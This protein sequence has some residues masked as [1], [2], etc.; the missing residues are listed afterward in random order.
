M[1]DP[2]KAE[3]NSEEDEDVEKEDDGDVSDRSKEDRELDEEAEDRLG[4]EADELFEN[5]KPKDAKKAASADETE[6]LK[7]LFTDAGAALGSALTALLDADSE[8]KAPALPKVEPASGNG[9]DRGQERLPEVPDTMDGASVLGDANKSDQW[10]DYRIGFRDTPGDAPRD[11]ALPGV[12]NIILGRGVDSDVVLTDE[13]VSRRHAML[14][15]R[16]GKVFVEDLGSKNGTFI[17]RDGVQIEVPKGGQVELRPGDA[18]RLGP[19][20]E[21]PFSKPG[22]AESFKPA[23]YKPDKIEDAA[24][25]TDRDKADPAAS[26]AARDASNEYLRNHEFSGRMPDGFQVVGGLNLIDEKGQHGDSRRPSVVIDTRPGKDPALTKFL[27]D[28]KRDLAHLKDKPE[29]L[30]REIAKRA[31]AAM[32]PDGWSERAVDD[33][34]MKMRAENAG[35]RLMLGDFIEAA[36][37]GA[38]CGVCNHQAILTKL[39]FDSMYPN[40]SERPQMKLVRG[41]CGDDPAGRAPEYTMNHAWNTLTIDG[42]EK[43]FDPRQQ[44]YGD[45]VEARPSHHPGSEIPQLRPVDAAPPKPAADRAQEVYSRMVGREVGYG[46]EIWKIAAIDAAAGKVT[47]SANGMRNQDVESITKLNAGRELRIGET[48]KINRSNGS[49]DDGWKLVGYKDPE[50]KK[51]LIFTKDGAYQRTVPMDALRKDNEQVFAKAEQEATEKPVTPPVKP[52]ELT[53]KAREYGLVEGREVMHDGRKWF[54]SGT[55]DGKMELT[56]PSE[57]MM[58]PD[59]YKR[60]NGDRVPRVGD[61]INYQRSTGEVQKWRVVSYDAETGAMRVRNENAVK[62]TVPLERLLHENPDIRTGHK[63]ADVSAILADP[64]SKLRIDC[65]WTDGNSGHN[66]Y[67]GSIEGPNG[68]RFR[69]MVH[70]PPYNV[71]PGGMWE[72]A[73]KD[74]AAQKLAERMGAPGLFPPTVMRDGMMVQ[75]FVGNEGENIQTYLHQMSRQ[76]KDLRAAHRN[77]EDRIF[78]MMDKV[79]PKL[80]T[81]L[82]RTVA[83]T[84]LLGD[85]DQHGLNFVVERTGPNPGDVRIARIDMDHAFSRDGKPQIDRQGNYGDVVNGLFRYFSEKEMPAE[86]RAQIKKVSDELNPANAADR[87]AARNKFATETGLNRAR[88]DALADRAKELS[89]TGKFPKS[90]DLHARGGDAMAAPKDGEEIGTAKAAGG[91]KIEEVIDNLKKAG[92]KQ[93]KLDALKAAYEQLSKDPVKNEEALKAI[94]ALGDNTSGMDRAKREAI[95]DIVAASSKD[96]TIANTVDFAGLRDGKVSS[97][98]AGELRDTISR[99]TNLNKLAGEGIDANTIEKMKGDI[100]KVAQLHPDKAVELGKVVDKLSEP[101]FA[102]AFGAERMRS[103]AE[104]LSIP[105]RNE[106]IEPPFAHFLD[107]KVSKESLQFAA[108]RYKEAAISFKAP[109]GTDSFG[110]RYEYNASIQAMK[111]AKEEINGR[112]LVFIPAG[113]GSQADASGVDGVFMD[114]HTGKVYPIDWTANLAGKFESGKDRWAGSP[115]RAVIGQHVPPD[116]LVVKGLAPGDPAKMRDYIGSFVDRPNAAFVDVADMAKDKVPFPAF[117]ARPKSASDV[118]ELT[119]LKKY[120]DFCDRAFGGRPAGVL[121]ELYK[122]SKDAIPHYHA[123]KELSDRLATNLT[124]ELL[125]SGR[126]EALPLFDQKKAGVYEDQPNGER[127]WVRTND[128]TGKPMKYM[129]IELDKTLNPRIDGKD[130]KISKIRLYEDGTVI[131]IREYKDKSGDRERELVIG[132][133]KD[134]SSQVKARLE[135]VTDQGRKAQLQSLMDRMADVSAAKPIDFSKPNDLVQAFG[136]AVTQGGPLKIAAQRVRDL[137]AVMDRVK[138][139]DE[140]TAEE[141]I[142]RTGGKTVT[143]A[144]YQRIADTIAIEKQ[145]KTDTPKAEQILD[146]SAELVNKEGVDAGVARDAAAQMVLQSKTKEQALDFARTMAEVRALK[147]GLTDAQVNSLAHF[148]MELKTLVPDEKSRIEFRSN[149]LEALKN[150]KPGEEMKSVYDHMFRVANEKALAGGPNSDGWYHAYFGLESMGEK[151]LAKML[152]LPESADAKAIKEQLGLVGE[153]LDAQERAAGI[154]KPTAADKLNVSAI[155]LNADRV[156]D[157]HE[158]LDSLSATLKAS[159]LDAAERLK[160]KVFDFLSTEGV[161]DPI[162]A[163]KDNVDFVVS[164]DKTRTEVEFSEASSAKK[165]VKVDGKFFLEGTTTEVPADKVKTKLIIPEGLI[166]GNSGEL[167]RSIYSALLDIT[168]K[169]AESSAA[170]DRAGIHTFV[171]TELAKHVPLAGDVGTVTS[172]SAALDISKLPPVDT[173]VADLQITEK[174][175][176]IGGLD[177]EVSFAEIWSDRIKNLEDK[178]KA[179]EQKTEKDEKRIQEL[180]AAIAAEREFHAALADPKSKG[181][182]AAMKKAQELVKG[183]HAT[184]TDIERLA[185]ERAGGIGEAR[186]RLVAVTILLS[187]FIAWR[188]K[189]AAAEPP[190]TKSATAE[191]RP[192]GHED[193]PES[194]APPEKA[195][196]TSQP[197]A[198]V[199]DSNSAISQVQ[200]AAYVPDTMEGPGAGER[201]PGHENLDEGGAAGADAGDKKKDAGD[202]PALAA[203]LESLPERELTKQV[204]LRIL[205]E[206]NQTLAIANEKAKKDGKPEIPLIDEKKVKQEWD[207]GEF[208]PESQKLFQQAGTLL[209]RESL[210]WMQLLDQRGMQ[211]PPGSPYGPGMSE[212]GSQLREGDAL[213]RA[214][215]RNGEV[216]AGLG[217]GD[218]KPGQLPAEGDVT[219]LINA[220]SWLLKAQAAH[221][222]STVEGQVN[223]VQEQLGTLGTTK[224]VDWKPPKDATVEQLERWRAASVPWLETAIRVRTYSETIAAYNYVTTTQGNDW[225]GLTDGFKWIAGTKGEATVFSDAALKDP[226]FPGEVIRKPNGQVEVKLDMPEGLERTKENL[227]KIEKMERWLAKYGPDVDKTTTEL[228]KAMADQDRMLLWVEDGDID[229]KHTIKKEEV[230]AFKRANPEDPKNPASPSMLKGDE[231]DVGKFVKV[232][233]HNSGDWRIKAV[234]PDGSYELERRAPNGEEFNLKRYGFETQKCDKDGKPNPNGDYVKVTGYQDYLWARDHCYNNWDF[235]PWGMKSV[236]RKITMQP[237]VFHKNDMVPIIDN[238]RM[239]LM[240]AGKV[241]AWAS[242]QEWSKQTGNVVNAVVDAG[243]IVSGVYEARAGWMAAKAAGQTGILALSKAALKE[244]AWHLGLGLTG[245]GKQFI[246]NRLPYGKELMHIRH[247]AI[248]ADLSIGLLPQA[249]QKSIWGVLN[250]FNWGK[251]AKEVESAVE[252]YKLGRVLV[253]GSEIPLKMKWYDAALKG[254]HKVYEVGAFPVAD[255]YFLAQFSDTIAAVMNKGDKQ[256]ERLYDAM[257]R[258]AIARD[259]DKPLYANPLELTPEQL[260]EAMKPTVREYSSRLGAGYPHPS[261][262]SE[263]VGKAVKEA[264]KL[265]ADHA[266]RQK[267]AAKLAE[268]WTKGS[269]A[270]KNA[271]AAGLLELSKGADGKLPERINGITTTELQDRVNRSPEGIAKR[272]AELAQKAAGDADREAYR[273][274]LANYFK[275]ASDPAEKAAAARALIELSKGGDG[276]LAALPQPAGLDINA[277]KGYFDKTAEGLLGRMPDTLV[278]PKDNVERARLARDAA[279][280]FRSTT[281]SESDRV[282]AA[283]VLM[284]MR[285]SDKTEQ[286]IA[287]TSIKADALLSYLGER[288]RNSTNPEVKIAAGDILFRTAQMTSANLEERARMTAEGEKKLADAEKK[289]E[290]DK[291]NEQLKKAVA[292]A[293][294][295]LEDLKNTAKDTR[296]FLKKINYS[297][298]D[299]ASTLMEI[300]KSDAPRQVKMEAIASP[301]GVRLAA[302]AEHLKF[303]VEPSLLSETDD[304]RRIDGLSGLYGRDSKVI[305]KFFRDLAGDV[306]AD[307]DVRALASQSLNMLTLGRQTVNGVPMNPGTRMKVGSGGDVKLEGEGVAANHAEIEMGRDGKRYIRAVD[308][309]KPTWI[310]RNGEYQSVPA[311]KFTEIKPGDTVIVGDKEKGKALF[312]SNERTDAIAEMGARVKNGLD[313]PGSISGPYMEQLVKNLEAP[314]TSFS[315]LSNHQRAEIL[316]ARLMAAQAVKDLGAELFGGDKKRADKAVADALADCVQGN[317]PEVAMLALSKIDAASM[318]AMSP[319]QA[320]QVRQR[321]FSLLRDVP[322]SDIGHALRETIVR[323]FPEIFEGATK[324]QQGKAQRYLECLLIP[325]ANKDF[326]NQDRAVYPLHAGG[327][328]ELRVAA[329]EML[330]KLNPDRAGELAST[331]LLGGNYNGRKVEADAAPVRLEAVKTLEKV[332]PLEV[333]ELAL[334]ALRSEKDPAVLAKLWN[335]EFGQRPDMDPVKVMKELEA[336]EERVRNRATP[337]L[338]NDGKAAYE[339]YFAAHRSDWITQARREAM[340]FI[341]YSDKPGNLYDPKAIEARKALIYAATHPGLAHSAELAA[342]QLADLALLCGWN[343]D[344][345]KQYDGARMAKELA[346]PLE[347]ALL[348]NPSLE[349]EARHHLMSA[350]MLLKPGQN[351]VVSKDEAAL[352]LAKVL[353]NELKRMPRI[354]MYNYDEQGKSLSLQRRIMKE[355]QDLKSEKVTPLLEALAYKEPLRAVDE[356]GRPRLVDY[357]GIARRFEYDNKDQLLRFTELPS[358]K[359]FERDDKEP[360]SFKTKDGEVIKGVRVNTE[361]QRYPVEGGERDWARFDRFNVKGDY[362]DFCY[363]KDGKNYVQKPNGM[364]IEEQLKDGERKVT[365]TYPGAKESRE[366]LF[367]SKGA[368]EVEVTVTGKP[369]GKTE[370]WNLKGD[371]YGFSFGGRSSDGKQLNAIQSNTFNGIRVNRTMPWNFDRGQYQYVEGGFN[372]TMR[373]VDSNGAV[374]EVEGGGTEKLVKKGYGDSAAHPLR[375]VS[376]MARRLSNDQKETT[377]LAKQAAEAELRYIKQAETTDASFISPYGT[378]SD[379]T[380]MA[381]AMGKV[382]ANKDK[383]GY[384]VAKEIHMAMLSKPIEGAND[385]RLTVLRAALRDGNDMVRLV[386]AQYLMKSPV[387]LDKETIAF[388]AADIAKN[389][390]STGRSKAAQEILDELKTTDAKLVERAIAETPSN[391]RTAEGGRADGL[392]VALDA[393]YQNAFEKIRRSLLEGPKDVLSWNWEK[394]GQVSKELGLDMLTWSGRSAAERSAVQT[395]EG[396]L[397]SM[398]KFFMSKEE[399]E[400]KR[401]EARD[402][403]EPQ[404]WSTL[405]NLAL[406]AMEGK[407]DDDP[408]GVLARQALA[409]IVMSDGKELPVKD[410][411]RAVDK[412]VDAISKICTGNGPGRGDMEWVLQSL[413][414]ERIDLSAANRKKLVD[415]LDALADPEKGKVS[416]ENAAGIAAL[417]LEREMRFMPRAGQEGYKESI[418]LQTRLLDM[419]KKYGNR[420]MIPALQFVARQ[421]VDTTIRDKADET[422]KGIEGRVNAG[423]ERS[424]MQ[425]ISESSSTRFPSIK[426]DADPRLP[427][428][429]KAMT[430]SK[431]TADQRM[432]AAEI[433]LSPENKGIK[434]RDRK[435]AG[436]VYADLALK[437]ANEDIRYKAADTVLDHTNPNFTD[438]H[439]V[440]AARAMGDLSFSSTKEETREKARIATEKME[441]A[442]AAGAAAGLLDAAGKLNREAPDFKEKAGKALEGLVKLYEASDRGPAAQATL[443]QASQS[444]QA[445][446]GADNATA[447]K[448]KQM[449]K[450]LATAETPA[451]IKNN[452]DPRLPFLLN[453]IQGSDHDLKMAALAIA[454]RSNELKVDDLRDNVAVKLA[455][456]ET[457]K[458]ALSDSADKSA[459]VNLL[460]SLRS[461]NMPLA[462]ER[463]SKEFPKQEAYDLVAQMPKEAAQTLMAQSLQTTQRYITERQEEARKLKEA[464]DKLLKD[465]KYG[466]QIKAY[467]EKIG[468][469]SEFKVPDQLKIQPDVLRQSMQHILKLY[470]GSDRSAQTEAEL[471]KAYSAMSRVK[472]APAAELAE[473]GTLLE[474][475]AADMKSRPILENDPRLPQ[476]K[477]ILES[478]NNE[479]LKVGFAAAMVAAESGLKPGEP[480]RVDALKALAPLADSKDPAVRAAAEKVFSDLIAAIKL[481]IKKDDPQIKELMGNLPTRGADRARMELASKLLK[482]GKLTSDDYDLWAKAWRQVLTCVDSSDPTAK[483]EARKMLDTITKDSPNKSHLL[484]EYLQLGTERIG[485]DDPRNTDFWKS[486]K[487]F[488][489]KL[490]T[491]KD[492]QMYKFVDKWLKENGTLPTSGDE[493]VDLEARA[494]QAGEVKHRRYEARELWEKSLAAREKKDGADDLDL[495]RAR[496]RYAEWMGK[497]E[498]YYLNQTRI[499]QQTE[500]AVQAFKKQSPDAPETAELMRK[501]GGFY[502]QRREFDKALEQFT[503]AAKIYEKD[504]QAVSNYAQTLASQAALQY[505]K[506]DAAK[507]NEAV[508]KLHDLLKKGDLSDRDRSMVYASLYQNIPLMV[509]TNKDGSKEKAMTY[510]KELDA[511]VKDLK[512][513]DLSKGEAEKLFS[514]LWWSARNLDEQPGKTK[515]QADLSTTLFEKALEAGAKGKGENDTEFIGLYA[516]YSDVLKRQG[517]TDKAKEYMDRYTELWDKQRAR[518]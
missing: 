274:V 243:M 189:A 35:G 421:H 448:L 177:R 95:I 18:L 438:A 234:K 389:G 200:R 76:D 51:E 405:D 297:G 259:K 87:E 414:T 467:M 269:P 241:E 62:Q 225:P 380:K 255:V 74:L 326:F 455:V 316:V 198:P 400:K 281:A 253:E 384:D 288:V 99:L 8:K 15:M 181:H 267:L 349:A 43:I 303:A 503:D 300:L 250:P 263:L 485:R 310:V 292:D 91:F 402:S 122:R 60:L 342:R 155:L 462:L 186:G 282:A 264:L 393:K 277:V 439:R 322:A 270:E 16:D 308:A 106:L 174:G 314:M 468:Q 224:P 164:K 249:A 266:D 506:G 508:D 129:E 170:A 470:K 338:I 331:L 397:G 167:S 90:V 321:A 227:A 101:G 452:T 166:R 123:F 404:F 69:V 287:G 431:L 113:H 278:L 291:D 392:G 89:E 116:G 458:L 416:A 419:I 66:L 289:L 21:L 365:M 31:K 88:V 385:P 513:A 59:E 363:Q 203:K 149:M 480:A 96:A 501:L 47:I 491:P 306:S 450:D 477:Q 30:A 80:K 34:Y 375:E 407:R 347:A 433:L 352:V 451:G 348:S 510:L 460:K 71:G 133:I 84:A 109:L 161:K 294:K 447:A 213:F 428:L 141:I 207:R 201:A 190:A 194:F 230:E 356:K 236:D 502:E 298:A 469:S 222:K 301:N 390:S 13:K 511:S 358:G 442:E 344:Q 134:V 494:M 426:S 172:G 142:K 237:Q 418:E 228:A 498:D 305:E 479:K 165:V 354:P 108:E 302:L 311:D 518:R 223:Y 210:F 100:I 415:A 489:D 50:T 343:D 14:T 231:S 337:G 319:A 341:G 202:K 495:A 507:G 486:F 257:A 178:L 437:H 454:L 52:A 151:G 44:I 180:K 2:K 505:R 346:G 107:T 124:N 434:E 351:G 148:E 220:Y 323:K 159:P 86:V 242:A 475:A 196:A 295:E 146:K 179:E 387:A 67:I 11:Q 481:P 192:P 391:P 293:K 54:V 25:Q 472:E 216:P 396:N 265:P 209:G 324:D 114:P 40:D 70:K 381:D 240:P 371:Q 68:E 173:K 379:T 296:D 373:F 79:D 244:G 430:D 482:D 57:R 395:M 262:E 135:G 490:E 246:E 339:K 273:Q 12:K 290:G 336:L 383:D 183:F 283:I 325:D 6:A 369:D 474:T 410:R 127:R 476:I 427:F 280:V 361:M 412:A 516:Y 406:K 187:A 158:K 378:K 268:Q 119:G 144:E 92:V 422:K 487:G 46:G 353:E 32:Q 33:G 515:E 446:L 136:E 366:F 37:R 217:I 360:G 150:A 152:G 284:S 208:G 162:L 493:A 359:V 82:A 279:E 188:E 271:A 327:Q 382:L 238:G 3:V 413:L 132:H 94:G 512:V 49:V 36:K 229:K 509:N 156:K 333:H 299:F 184:E 191:D 61:E 73:T 233:P 443:M 103:F 140:K 304:N 117:G 320:D 372:K 340:G 77:L 456:D 425:M 169:G 10:K 260:K 417:A 345:W 93:E 330:T 245:F 357:G 163:N 496:L 211:F 500:L 254:A 461:E 20:L 235:I 423:V 307:K 45:P 19:K 403:V 388:V 377:E 334:K 478:S 56:R 440:A 147:P 143:N 193:L 157:F 38:G 41:F 248:L 411:Q 374:Y 329:L 247:W 315:G 483:A 85:H 471:L 81:E 112:K 466:E 153:R 75:K 517:Q 5:K 251:S 364:L 312:F 408:Q 429:V 368:Q 435:A 436:S 171:S 318:A 185:R 17:V 453:A 362:G 160:E 139:I 317:S 128:V 168:N 175:I 39:A 130:S 64:K 126:P 7:S 195:A 272:T 464:N 118:P 212:S 313:N 309:S 176:K 206:I 256:R 355:L 98:Q 199:S 125:I 386:A 332:L 58:S 328:P 23:G 232:P 473:M 205:P 394:W 4:Y 137:Q 499:L 218:L 492:D 121:G 219:K 120:V 370:T 465:P 258:H 42:R 276:K 350:Y 463:I 445:W 182:E 376:L 53:D 97:A 459:A 78:H 131:G 27:E 286:T 261:A 1:A 514:A 115:D 409:F 401:Q 252:A 226:D 488:L 432:R 424:V 111:A 420:E 9:D 197:V 367:K 110:N 145:F 204:L 28:C 441:G 72:R 26:K 104:I 215:L 48:Y 105:V 449:F 399:L 102:K 504:P 214:R 55:K 275:N 154:V 335:L 398:T 138:G 65:R 497:G 457:I 83:F 444:A 63:G 24:S 239:R 221:K 484:K 29:E 285:G 22:A